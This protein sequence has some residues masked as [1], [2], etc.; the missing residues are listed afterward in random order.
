MY[1]RTQLIMLG[2]VLLGTAVIAASAYGGIPQPGLILY[3]KVTDDGGNLLTQGDLVWTFTPTAGGEPLTLTVTLHELTGTGGPYS[4]RI[5][6]PLEAP[7][8]SF[9]ASGEAIPVATAS[10]EYVQECSVVATSIQISQTVIFST[11][12][13]GSAKR[14]D[15]CAD[16]D[17]VLTPYHSADIDRNHR[18]NLSEFLRVVE[19]NTATLTHEYHVD[20]S[21]LDGYSVGAGNRI[22][23]P[24]SGDYYGGADWRISVHEIVRMIDLFASTP[25]HAYSPDSASE[26]GFRKG[27][28]DVAKGAS[29][30]AK[31]G[32]SPADIEFRRYVRGG[33]IGAGASLEIT[34]IIS[35]STSDP[36]SA[37][38]LSEYLPEGWLFEGAAQKSLAAP[39]PG[40]SG[41][42][43]F[44]WYPVPPLPYEFSYRVSFSDPG[45]VLAGIEALAGEGLYRTKTGEHQTLVPVGLFEV[46]LGLQDTDGDG[47][48]DA[49]ET[50]SDSDGD[51]IPDLADVDSDNDGISDQEEAFFDGDPDYNPYDP[52]YNP[53]GT[54]TNAASPD[55]DNDG[56]FDP[57]EIEDGTSPV[58]PESKAGPVPA[59]GGLGSVLAAGL[60]ALAGVFG[61][62]RA[63]RTAR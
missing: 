13:I 9:P 7:V 34:V 18:F 20:S 5:V 21:T 49:E 59:A 51:G 12:D 41:D 47:I 28:G 30:A 44:A 55:S 40:A 60:V 2:C 54:D 37:V 38:G 43:E 24:H 46:G 50:F 53:D 42:L 10:V 29:S 26:D 33:A 19:L 56:V 11:A 31:A 3:G 45:S 35:G 23:T 48:L 6:V 62:R 1:R 52:I 36:L 57:D 32:I 4:Y 61:L 63:R 17:M 39:I 58:D 16:C 8:E 22:G 14:V 27:S 25:E 15:V